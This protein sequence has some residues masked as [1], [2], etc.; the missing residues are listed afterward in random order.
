MRRCIVIFGEAALDFCGAAPVREYL[1]D[2]F[3]SG[4]GHGGDTFEQSAAAEA[5]YQI[6]QLANLQHDH[7][8]GARKRLV[9]DLEMLWVSRGSRASPSHFPGD[10][11]T[12]SCLV[13]CG[14]SE[15]NFPDSGPGVSHEYHHDQKWPPQHPL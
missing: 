9:A 14:Q 3:K 4:Y 15:Y 12:G 7:Q 5:L 1:Y 8:T 6:T 10:L 11:M 2:Y 13:V